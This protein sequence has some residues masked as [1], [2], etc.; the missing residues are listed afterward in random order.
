MARKSIPFFLKLKNIKD[1]M[2][3]LSLPYSVGKKAIQNYIKYGITCCVNCG[4][5][6]SADNTFCS[7]CG[8]LGK[9]IRTSPDKQ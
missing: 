3:Q 9:S 6:H 7:G 5:I 8:E 2:R 4:V 1:R